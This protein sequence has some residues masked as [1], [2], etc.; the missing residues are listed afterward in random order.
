MKRPNLR[1]EPNKTGLH[2]L[3]RT[4]RFLDRYGHERLDLTEPLVLVWGD[5]LDGNIVGGGEKEP[6][7]PIGC[8]VFSRGPAKSDE[9][10]GTRELWLQSAPPGAAKGSKCFGI[11]AFGTSESDRLLCQSLDPRV[12]V[13]DLGLRLTLLS[14]RRA[15]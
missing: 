10:S 14:P 15:P 6:V 7:G 4:E 3:E 13:D 5:R 8:T 1:F 12:T 9:R 2:L 11:L